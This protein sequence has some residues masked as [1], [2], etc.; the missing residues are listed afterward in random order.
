M[1][2]ILANRSII[3]MQMLI[4]EVTLGVIERTKFAADA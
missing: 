1:M 3:A 2:I 4:H